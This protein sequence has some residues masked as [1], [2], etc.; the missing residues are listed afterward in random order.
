LPLQVPLV[1]NFAEGSLIIQREM[2]LV[3][4]SPQ[5]FGYFYVIK[6]L[7][8]MPRVISSFLLERYSEYLALVFSNV[9][10]PKNPYYVAGKKVHS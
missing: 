8:M 1:D 10:G 4:K 6:I 3:K 2:N 9:P 7:M 5:P